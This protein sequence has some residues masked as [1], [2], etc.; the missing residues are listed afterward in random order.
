MS[1][2]SLSE[3]LAFPDLNPVLRKLLVTHCMLP[4]GCVGNADAY[5]CLRCGARV[6]LDWKTEQVMFPVGSVG[7][8]VAVVQAA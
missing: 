6:F 2:V 8:C 5:N 4:A 3:L 7:E 1:L